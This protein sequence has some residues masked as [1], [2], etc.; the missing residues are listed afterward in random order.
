MGVIIEIIVQIS[1][2]LIDKNNLIFSRG[3]CYYIWTFECTNYIMTILKQLKLF[4]QFDE[5]SVANKRLTLKCC[6]AIKW[7]PQAFMLK[8]LAFSVCIGPIVSNS[9]IWVIGSL[10][11][12]FWK[13]LY[14]AD[15]LRNSTSGEHF[16]ERAVQRTRIMWEA[17]TRIELGGEGWFFST[18]ALPHVTPKA[19]PV[20]P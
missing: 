13:R 16:P 5:F 4:D 1:R 18:P 12:Q 9:I 14:G 11:K 3:V 20:R 8:S 6:S 2:L 19:G 17:S 7:L 15:V 10:G